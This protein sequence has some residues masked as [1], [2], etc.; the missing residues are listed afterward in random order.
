MGPNDRPH[1]GGVFFLTIHFP[2]DYT[3]KT[4]RSHSQ[5]KSIK[6]PKVTFTTKIYHPK[7]NSNGSICLDILWLQWSPTLSKILLSICSLFSN[8]NPNDLLVPEIAHT[9]KANRE[10]MRPLWIA[11]VPWLPVF[12]QA[13]SCLS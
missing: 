6:L 4:Q 1:Q 13:S 8:P 10:N 11:F 2:M 12:P 7:I 9:Y 5:L 3:F